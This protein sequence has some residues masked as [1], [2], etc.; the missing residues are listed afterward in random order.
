MQRVQ[1]PPVYFSP[2]F[3]IVSLFNFYWSIGGFAMSYHFQVYSKVNQLHTYICS[4]FLKIILK[5]L[6]YF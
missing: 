3:P 6:A 2:S 5:C 1:A 4:L